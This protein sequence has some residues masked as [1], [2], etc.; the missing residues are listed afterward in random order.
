MAGAGRF[1]PSPT[2][3]PHFGTLLAAVA[4]HL[5]ARASGD[6]WLLRIEDIDPGRCVPGAADQMLRT[7]E[8]HGLH[9]DG[10]PL[11][12]ST[13]RE[14]Y[15]AALEQLL[16]EKK[17]FPCACSRRD[18]DSATMGIDTKVYPGTCRAGIR[19]GLSAHSVRLFV[20]PCDIQFIDG[21]Y[22]PQQ[23]ALHRAVGD[24]IIQRGDD[25]F[26][27]QLAVVVDDAFQ[28]ITQVVRGADLLPSTAR[29]IYLQQQLRLSTPSYAHIPLVCDAAGHKLSKSGGAASID[30]QPPHINLIRA[31]KL[32]GLQPLPELDS[33]DDLLD[34]AAS[35]WR[36]PRVD[37]P[38]P[39]APRDAR[40][41]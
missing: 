40:Y 33:T 23:Q 24:F 25:V 1:A 17:A 5:N 36:L 14:A 19:P 27:Y 31:L 21:V 18:L 16:R 37:S 35:V 9:W 10:T 2:G 13:R 32:L 7:L 30:R 4:S 6:R 15:Q 8:Q 11:F 28:G 38:S 22:G 29:Q 12:Q 41:E 39:N 20:Q 3:A 26:A 34:W